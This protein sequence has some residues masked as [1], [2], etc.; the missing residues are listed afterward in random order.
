M[1]EIY[2][3][4]RCVHYRLYGNAPVETIED[5]GDGGGGGSGGGGVGLIED[6]V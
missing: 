3:N 2:L 4:F 5:G 1:T 6:G